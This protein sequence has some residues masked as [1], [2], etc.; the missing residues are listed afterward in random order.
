MIKTKQL[1]KLSTAVAEIRDT[2]ARKLA[3]EHPPTV[4]DRAYPRRILARAR[5]RLDTMIRAIDAQTKKEM[6]K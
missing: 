6:F 2:V 5:S 1:T 4:G 3:M